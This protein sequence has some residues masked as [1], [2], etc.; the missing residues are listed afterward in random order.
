MTCQRV[1][2]RAGVAA[3]NRVGL[4]L[5]ILL[6]VHCLRM[7][8]VHGFREPA[9][10]APTT[11]TE[12]VKRRSDIMRRLHR[13]EGQHLVFVRYDESFSLDDEWVYN[14]G[15]LN[16][17]R[18]IFAHDLGDRRNPELMAAFPERSG[19]LLIVSPEQVRLE[20]YS[21]VSQVT[22]ITR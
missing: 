20:P 12:P 11:R 10:A 21:P 1:A 9:P 17:A 3:T 2:R 4:V 13:Q 5:G 18:V 22:W 7:A 16:S 8:A 15:D 6:A 14:P 19:W